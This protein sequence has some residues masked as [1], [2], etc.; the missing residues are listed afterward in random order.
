MLPYKLLTFSKEK[1]KRN[2][3]NTK[4]FSAV[5]MEKK[6]M[7][8]ILENLMTS[9]ESLEENTRLEWRATGE[10]EQATRWNDEVSHSCPVFEDENGKRTFEDTGKPWMVDCYDNLPKLEFTDRDNARLAAIQ[11]VR[12]TLAA[13]A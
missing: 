12:E 11:R 4:D 6:E 5:V 3:K 10:K 2:M 8:D 1:E 9:L 13:L 7:L